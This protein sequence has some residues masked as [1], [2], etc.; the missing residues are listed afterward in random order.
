MQRYVKCH[1]ML[2]FSTVLFG[3]KSGACVWRSACLA[4][5]YK[6][7][8]RASRFDCKEIDGPLTLLHIGLDPSP[9]SSV[10]SS[11][12]PQLANRWRN[13][14]R[15]DRCFRYLQGYQTRESK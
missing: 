6:S 11:G 9:I 1:I 15:G 7:L 14:E 8:C 3:D 12:T 4:Q 10:G 13:W 2:L 5:L